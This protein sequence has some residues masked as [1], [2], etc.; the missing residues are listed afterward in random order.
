MTNE[1]KDS[2]LTDGNCEERWQKEVTKKYLE[3]Q[4]E[5]NE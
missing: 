4:Q 3:R 1:L 5:R 2:W